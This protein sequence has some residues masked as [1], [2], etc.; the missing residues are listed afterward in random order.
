MIK[1]TFPNG[2]IKEFNNPITGLDIAKGIS[3]SLAKNALFIKFNDNYID[4][5]REITTD[6]TI[7]ILTSKDSETL[8]LLRHSAAHIMAQ[9]IKE[10]YPNVK[11]AIGP[12]IENGFYYDIDCETKITTDDFPKIE[13]KMEEIIKRNL[14]I[15]RKDIST[16]EAKKLFLQLGETYKIELI[17]DLE[18]DGIN[19]VSIYTQGDF[20]DLCRGPHLP[21]TSKLEIGTFKIT[22]VAGAYWRGDVK[23]KMLQRIY[24]TAWTSKDE[25]EK[26]IKM[27]EEAEKRDHR[28]IGVAMDLFHFEPDFAPGS[29]FWHP[30]GWNLFQKLISYMRKKQ[31]DNGYIEVS[32]PTIMNRCLWETSG[33]WDKYKHNMYTAKVQDEDTEFAVKPMNCPGGVLIFKQG[34]RSYRDLP[35]R[36]AEFGKVNRY[37]PSG[38]LHGLLR[39][40]EFTQDDAHIFCTT[41]QMEEECVKVIKL[42]MEIYKE[43]G[44]SDVKIKLSTRPE[45]RIGSDETWDFLEKSLANAL[46]HHGYTYTIFP[47]EGAFYGPKLEF[48]LRDAIGRDWQC[49][50]LQV[51]MNL[52]ERF[53]L[54]YI[55]QDG[56]KHRPVMLHRALFGSLER[57]TG[58][59]IENF[60][61]KLPLWLSPIQVAVATIAESSSDYAKKVNDLLKNE[62]ISTIL[63]ISNEKISYKIRQ[64]STSKVPVIAVIG[65]KEASTN[66][67]TIRRLG[68]EEQVK[69]TLNEFIDK[70]KDEISS[71]K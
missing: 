55:G 50:T 18:K 59:L 63:D 45:K 54:N 33:H 58:I 3:T 16:A 43:F 67:I 35:I 44:F 49:G 28:K 2:D 34:I 5:T 13:A 9:A 62:N 1:I 61:G 27:Q 64:Y 29:V 53:D 57:F 42:I 10:L 11:F 41:E 46:E 4:L 7:Q 48:V 38:A 24:A 25:L 14:P 12:S 32:T 30:N 56:E 68:S 23:N 8:P 6:G 36:M 71:K 21:S 19:E 22:S 26:Y 39:V 20:T 37:E 31:E 52:P 47:G 66:T 17:N 60:A 65:D 51:D 40:R 69:L 15:T 70:I